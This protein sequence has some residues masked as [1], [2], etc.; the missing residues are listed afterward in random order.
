MRWSAAARRLGLRGGRWSAAGTARWGAGRGALDSGSAVAGRRRRR[1]E[2]RKKITV[3]L[4]PCWKE[5]LTLT[6]VGQSI[7]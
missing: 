2:K 3:A 7:K 4:V 1:L 5:T 6:G